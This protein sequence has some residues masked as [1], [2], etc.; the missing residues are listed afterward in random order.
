MID[1]IL[2]LLYLSPTFDQ[3]GSI[4]KEEEE[5]DTQPSKHLLHANFVR[6]NLFSMELQE[7]ISVIFSFVGSLVLVCLAVLLGIFFH[8]S[9][10]LLLLLLSFI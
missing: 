6:V 2:F 5:T 1:Y 7:I 4:K 3:L 8:L 10:L 9:K